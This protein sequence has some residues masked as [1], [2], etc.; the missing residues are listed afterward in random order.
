MWVKSKIAA[1]ILE[2]KYET[3]KKAT[4][5][6]EKAGKKFCTIN[7]QNCLFNKLDGNVGGAS[8]KVLQIWLDDNLANSTL[9]DKELNNISSSSVALE[10]SS[11]SSDATCD[12]QKIDTKLN[13][14][15]LE[16][17]TKIKAVNEL[18]S[19]PN[20]L[21]KTLWGKSVA[22][23][24]NVSLKTL[25]EWAKIL[26]KDEVEIK[27]ESID[28]KA[29]FD[30]S[31][32]NINALEWSVAYMLHNPLASKKAVFEALKKECEK[33][34]WK[35][36]AYQSFC[37]Q[38][39]KN[40]IKAMLLKVTNGS[41]GVRNEIAPFVRRDLNAYESMEMICGDQIVFDFDVI[42]DDGSKINPNA[43]VWI[44]MGSG[45]IIGVDVVMGKYNKFGVARSMKMALN[46]A[47]PDSVYTDNGKPELSNHIKGI[48]SQLSGVEFRDF[49]E[50]DA[51]I[52]H[53]KAKPGNSRAKP[54]ENIFNH[55]QRWM[56]E[57][58]I[59]KKGGAS[60]HKDRRNLAQIMKEYM[61]KE[62]LK[63]NEFIEFFISAIK[64]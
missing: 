63:W 44:D 41:R 27:N 14:K 12:M 52:I 2:V 36:G 1:E 38:M 54:I 29:K 46:W 43:Y 39:D 26:K 33:N 24:Y 49:G 37:R 9:K 50:M 58:I 40:E 4:Q 23:K 17:M 21:K 19:C 51:R 55:V 16:N 61:K 15:D 20:N 13:I 18:N 59:S 30:S 57:D 3:V 5:R 11:A 45:A 10:L 62:P 47:V 34:G 31:A 22:K 25:Y 8:G 64:K 42:K 53:T 7:G 6:A 56:A 28:F 60:Y 32:F 35:I 48:I